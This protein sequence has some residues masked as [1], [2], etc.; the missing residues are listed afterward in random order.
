MTRFRADR[1]TN[2][3]SRFLCVTANATSANMPAA[4]R[5]VAR[6]I[7]LIRVI[8]LRSPARKLS[9]EARMSDTE[10]VSSDAAAAETIRSNSAGSSKVWSIRAL[11]STSTPWTGT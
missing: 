10:T 7:E 3:D 5:A 11:R 2:A 4:A 9:R 8:I 6:P 1:D